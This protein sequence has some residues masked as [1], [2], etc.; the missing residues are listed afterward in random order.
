VY[1]SRDSD[2]DLLW[3]VASAETADVLALQIAS[4]A[5]RAPMRIDGEFV[6][7]AGAGVQ[8]WEWRSPAREV[9]AKDRDGVRLL[10]RAEFLS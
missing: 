6:A 2:L 7:P 4:I 5:E 9:I 8:W 1:L 3:R 10:N